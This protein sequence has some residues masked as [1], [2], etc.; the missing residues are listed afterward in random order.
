MPEGHF[1][2][3]PVLIDGKIND[4]GL[5]LR[6]SNPEYSMQYAVTN[7]NRNIYVCVYTKDASFHRRILKAGMSISFDPKGE[8]E[9]KM[10]LDFPVKKPDEPSENR[11]GNPIRN[12]DTRVVEEQLIFQSDYYNTTGFLNLENGQFDITYQK[13]NIQVAIKL[14]DDSSL[15]YE[16]AIPIKYILGADLQPGYV[17]RNFSVGLVI[18]EMHNPVRNPNNGYHP[19]S[20]YGGGTRGMH[21]MGGGRNYNSN[22]NPTSKPEENWYQFSL[23]YKK[24]R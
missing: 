22:N 4:W 16:A 17:P 18:N 6:F 10:S 19:H 7:D 13:N 15:V 23:V 20:S 24:S 2:D 1:Q 8:K 11:N 12:T 5:P 3:T 9:K 14:S 21:G